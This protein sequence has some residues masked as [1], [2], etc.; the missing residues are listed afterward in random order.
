MSERAKRA[1]D[2]L[3]AL[4]WG[5]NDEYLPH[6]PACGEEMLTKRQRYCHNCGA[7]P[8][9]SE[10]SIADLEAAIVAALEVK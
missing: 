3:S 8:P 9:A 4:G 6:C 10:G 1:A 2:V 5:V 7:K